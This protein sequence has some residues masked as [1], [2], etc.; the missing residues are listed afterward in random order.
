VPAASLRMQTGGGPDGLTNRST[1]CPIRDRP[2]SPTR[3][4]A[5]PAGRARPHRQPFRV[6]HGAPGG[7]LSPAAHLSVRSARG[8]S[9]SEL[10]RWRPGSWIPSPRLLAGRPAQPRSLARGALAD[11][12]VLTRPAIPP[13]RSAKHRRD[14][15][16]TRAHPHRMG[17]APRPLPTPGGTAAA[18]RP[19]RRLPPARPYR[20]HPSIPSSSAISR[21]SSPRLQQPTRTNDGVP[22]WVEDDFR[23]YCHP[24]L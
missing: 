4:L 1:R 20:P 6:D 15:A 9:R 10:R 12:L 23:A 3:G 2:P 14:H 17:R 19:R 16:H 7:A 13:P 21:P 24:R 8:S 18:R 11:R 22:Q 5:L